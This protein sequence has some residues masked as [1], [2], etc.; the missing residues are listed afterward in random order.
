MPQ[1]SLMSYFTRPSTATLPTSFIQ[2]RIQVPHFPQTGPPLDQDHSPQ[3]EVGII[4]TRLTDGIEAFVEPRNRIVMDLPSTNEFSTSVL[5]P[6]HLNVHISAV[7][8]SHLPTLKR[9]TSTLLPV[10]Y[11]D[12]FFSGA[13]DDPISASFSRVALYSSTAT[14]VGWIRCRLEPSSEE[15]PPSSG[16]QSDHN[17]VYMLALCLLA[18]HRGQGIATALVESVLRRELLSQY[19]VRSVY[20]HVWEANEEA[21]GWYERRGFRRIMLMESYYRKLK[22]GGA[23]IMRKELT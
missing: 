23:W 19:N 10:K 14:P 2:D 21:L 3:N 22:P 18:P 16:T 13:V 8:A 5:I 20:A 6:H 7:A 11:P 17:Q 15:K 12:A 4:P 1:T 9:L